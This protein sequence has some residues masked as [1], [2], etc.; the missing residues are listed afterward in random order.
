MPL[1]LP[2]LQIGLSCIL[3]SRKVVTVGGKDAVRFLQSLMTND[4]YKLDEQQLMYGAFLNAK[5]ST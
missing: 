5:V 4:I 3:K 2:G 1:Y